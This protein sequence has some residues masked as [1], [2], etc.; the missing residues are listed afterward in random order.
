MHL[1]ANTLGEKGLK[2]SSIEGFKEVKKF[3]LQERRVR[4]KQRKGK[5]MKA[6]SRRFPPLFTWKVLVHPCRQP[7]LELHPTPK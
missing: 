6:I 4:G 3:N 7:S 1:D 2:A 5:N